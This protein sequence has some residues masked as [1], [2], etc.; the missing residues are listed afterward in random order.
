MPQET[1]L[2]NQRFISLMIINLVVSI[3]FSMVYTIMA[4]YVAGMG[5][6]I[7]MAGIVTGAF[8]ISSMVMRPVSGIVADRIDR[9]LL[10]VV[11]TM[12]MGLAILGYSMVQVTSLLI[13]LRILHGMAFAISTTVNM[14]IIPGIVPHRQIGEAICYF[15]LSQS[16]AL[17]FGPSLGLSLAHNLSYQFAFLVSAVLCVIGAIVAIPLK[18]TMAE[19]SGNKDVPRRGLRL[20]DI[21]VPKCLPFTMLEVSIAS[22]AGIETSL[23]AL[24]GIS[25][26]I[27][28][29]GWYFTISAVT[30]AVC[31]L[32]FGK[33]IDKYGT[34]AVYPGM[35]LMVIGLIILWL[36]SA[37][38]MF[39]VA[40]VVKTLGASLAKPALQAASVKSVQ[41][42]RRGA[43][44]S[45][46][47]IGT[48]IGQG[49]SPMIG[50]RIV[51]LNGGHYNVVFG[52]FAVPLVVAS[53]AYAF[54]SKYIKRRETAAS[55]EV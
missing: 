17:A 19:D 38:W 29:I 12:L 50:G 4:S 54:I 51:D 42:E 37:P 25:Q 16:L 22:V 32:A 1:K 10:L 36:Q 6:S 53:I 18:M 9:K 13:A 55:K 47:Y 5:V 27:Q 34:F 52:I 2:I 33:M 26:G 11:S 40:A 46:Y 30:V 43:A 44:V 24:Y 14:A 23:M 41:P 3:S 45:T 15:G 28:N 21:F 49:L 7:A 39:G 20:S 48:D 31:R 8:S 35:A